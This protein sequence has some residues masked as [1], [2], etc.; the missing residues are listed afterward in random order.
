MPPR[1]IPELL[2]PAG[3]LEAVR[4][5]IANGA[6]AVY[7]GASRFNARDDGAQLSLD[8]LEQACLLAHERGARI[9]LTLNVLIKPHELVDA[10]VY[11]GECIDRG[12]DAAIV[13]DVG[14]IRLIAKAYPGF[15]VHG[16]TQMAHC[17]PEKVL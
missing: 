16:S 11:L 10:L 9:Y 15:E 4:A 2:A 3:S 1:P 8:D 5:A 6:D 14:L 7:C 12:I 17:H 13:Q